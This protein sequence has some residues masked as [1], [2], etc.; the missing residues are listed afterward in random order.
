[1]PK[2]ICR[3][4]GC[5]NLI[6]KT[7]VYCTQHK[8]IEKIEKKIYNEQYDKER[9]NTKEHKFYKTKE[10]VQKRE[11][12]LRDHKGID[13]Y[14]YYINGRE[15]VFASV[16]HHIEEL[17]KNWELRLESTNLIPVSEAT[18]AMIHSVYKQGIQ[19]RK[20]MQEV[21]RDLATRYAPL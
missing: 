1:M 2:R 15:D 20:A 13:L 10:W 6:D 3:K 12:V 8:K 21:L 4:I 16:V 9:K 14:E 18:H 11:E 19:E 7:E 17:N 5:N